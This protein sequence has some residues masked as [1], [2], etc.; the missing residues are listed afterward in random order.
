MFIAIAVT[1]LA[2]VSGANVLPGDVP[3]AGPISDG[4][5]LVGTDIPAG[6][7]TSDGSGGLSGSC[8]WA[9]HKNDGGAAG[10]I[11]SNHIG[12]GRAVVRARTGE[13]LELSLGCTYVKQ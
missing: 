1:A 6:T 2:L 7:Y 3:V 5:Y 11:I 9:R 12:A 13:V 4:T 10:D 8:Y